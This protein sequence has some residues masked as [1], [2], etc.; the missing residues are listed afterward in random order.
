MTTKG[1]LVVDYESHVNEDVTDSDLQSNIVE[2]SVTVTIGGTSRRTTKVM[3]KRKKK[4]DV[5]GVY[6][7]NIVYREILSE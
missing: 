6:T 4:I 3:L 5:P 7:K 1:V 2:P